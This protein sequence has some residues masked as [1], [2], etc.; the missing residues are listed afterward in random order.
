[1]E[2]LLASLGLDWDDR[3]LSV[4]ATGRAV[5][6]ASVWQVREPLYQRSS[7]RAR[8]YQRQLSTLRDYLDYRVNG[9]RG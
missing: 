8:H 3:C 6:T 5:K 9:D 4:P 1:M 7:G 2:R